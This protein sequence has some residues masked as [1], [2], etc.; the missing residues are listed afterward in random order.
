MERAQTNIRRLTLKAPLSGMVAQENLFR[1]NSMGHAQEGDQLYRGQPLVSIFDPTECWCVCAVGEPDVAALV[2]GIRGH[3]L[4]GRLPRSGPSRAFRVFQPRGLVGVRQPHQ[5][6]HRRLPASTRRDPH[7]LPDLSA[8]V[9]LEQPTCTGGAHRVRPQPPSSRSEPQSPM[10]QSP[11]P[12]LRLRKRLRSWLIFVVFLLVV[13]GAA[14]GSL[15]PPPGPGQ[16]HFSRRPRPG[17]GDFLVIIRCR[18]EL[19][20]ARSVSVYAPIVPQLRIAWLAPSGEPSSR[21]ARP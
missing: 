6:L 15:P 14:A 16:C 17:K 10:P 5:D 7:L 11:I 20:A 21:R 2:A 13:G 12:N 1:S 4:P 9:V 3:R 19:K 18:G 8:A